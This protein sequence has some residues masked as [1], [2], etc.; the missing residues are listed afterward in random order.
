[1]SNE[2]LRPLEAM[3]DSEL[4]DRHREES[5]LLEIISVLQRE[6]EK[7]VKPYMDRLVAIQ[8]MKTPV[9]Y[10][11]GSFAQELMRNAPAKPDNPPC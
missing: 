1:M 11:D 2:T 9:M 8:S 4:R 10:V 6:Y 3:S 7:A 5:V